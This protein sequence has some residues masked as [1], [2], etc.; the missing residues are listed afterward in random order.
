MVG[1]ALGLLAAVVGVAEARAEP[2]DPRLVVLDL[3]HPVELGAVVGEQQAKGASERVH[4]LPKPQDL[5]RD[6]LLGLPDPEAELEADLGPDE[7]DGEDAVGV[8]HGADDGVGL[9]RDADAGEQGLPAVV[10][11]PSVGD[12]GGRVGPFPLE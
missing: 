10:Y 7:H 2:M 9:D 12:S 3:R 11:G 6:G 4:R 8:A 5:R 1:L